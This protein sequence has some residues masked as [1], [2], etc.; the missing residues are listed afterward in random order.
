MKINRICA[1]L[2]ISLSTLALVATLFNPGFAEEETV[3]QEIK[4]LKVKSAKL[5]SDAMSLLERVK[6]LRADELERMRRSVLKGIKNWE[7]GVTELD[8]KG[9]KAALQNGYAVAKGYGLDVERLKKLYGNTKLV[10]RRAE[11]AAECG[12]GIGTSKEFTDSVK[13]TA[14][15]GN[16]LHYFNLVDKEEE[17]LACAQEK[18]VAMYKKLSRAYLRGLVTPNAMESA[19]SFRKYAESIR[20]IS[21]ADV[22]AIAADIEML[23]AEQQ[24]VGD[25]L[26]V[27]PIVGDALDALSAIEGEEIS[28]KKLSAAERVLKVI[29]LLTPNALEMALKR[30]PALPGKI[31]GFLKKVI[32]PEGGRLDA[33]AGKVGVTAGELQAKAKKILN[34]VGDVGEK[35]VTKFAN[36]KEAVEAL[37][38]EMPGLPGFGNRSGAIKTSNMVES[39]ADA[40]ADIAKSR[41]EIVMV[42]PINKHAKKLLEEGG[43]VAKGMHI[44]AKSSDMPFLEGHIPVDQ[45]NSKLGTAMKKAE[46][47][48]KKAKAAGNTEQVTA[49]KQEM[50]KLNKDI[51]E[52]KHEVLQSIKGG[53]AKADTVKVNG[54]ELLSVKN[55][56]TGKKY[57]VVSD[58]KGGFL[59]PKTGKAFTQDPQTG[60]KL[61]E[62]WGTP[63][64]VRVL[65]DPHTGKK[66]TADYDLLGIGSSKGAGKVQLDKVVHGNIGSREYATNFE[67]N[68]AVRQKGFKGRVVEH[69]PAT[70]FK[71]K[72]DYPITAYLPTGDVVNILNENQL[73]GF[74]HTMKKQGYKGLDPHPEW[75]WGKYDPVKGW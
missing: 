11:F 50:K 33:L 47:K 37:K 59:D 45:A 28:G 4:D 27:V 26:S 30:F 41:N 72:P 52:Y 2:R 43:A 36:A 74:F 12:T 17:R 39:H 18:K 42:R 7:D 5:N 10:I 51:E 3:S 66:F 6:K 19:A 46:D 44:K 15:I 67:L 22:D 57:M 53:Y 38:K 1:C 13:D 55:P 62:K 21:D 68:V 16:V 70:H 56:K 34:R 60:V 14:V 63:N 23:A 8:G 49:L 32:A 48:L 9:L 25:F 29:L 65:V 73:K 61:A 31:V 35:A 71:G 64:K 69:G 75:G 24:L 58:G 20:A 40:F 54:K